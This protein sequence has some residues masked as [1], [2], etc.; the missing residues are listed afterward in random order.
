MEKVNITIIGA[1]VVGLAISYALSQENNDILVVERHKSFGQETSSRN[2][3]VIHAGLYY[4][5]GSLKADLCIRGKALLY[6]FCAKNNIGHK[7]LGKIIVGSEKEEISHIEDIYN[8]A[9]ACGVT[10]IRLIDKPEIVKLEPSVTSKAALYSPETGILDTHSLMK[11]FADLSIAKGAEFAYGV[12]VVD[13]ERKKGFYNLTVKE[14]TGE[15]FSFETDIVI[16]C[17]GL[18]AD[19][20]AAFAGIDIIKDSYKLYYNKGQYFRLSNPNRFKVAGLIYPPPTK[21]DLGIH[22]TP[23]LAGGL[24][25]GPDAKYVE[26]IDYDVNEASKADFFRSVSRYLSG[27]NIED[28]Y[29]DTAG[30]RPKTQA[31]GEDVKDF[32]IRNET[33]KGLPNFINLL[34]IESPGLT[35]ALAIAEMVNSLII[36]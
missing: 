26:K 28:L 9:K 29:P 15:T 13:I 23:D 34:G 21:T 27:L 24:R 18:D 30:I 2:S 22:V 32:I 35:S 6:E 12:E 25:L 36:R 5:P 33:D 3:E 19:K 4:P 16:N 14:P 11:R 10:N 8:N 31:P 1:G 17:A 20:I 7:K